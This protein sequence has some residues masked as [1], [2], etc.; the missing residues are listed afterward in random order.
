[1]TRDYR[2]VTPH[3]ELVVRRA[4][5]ED[6]AAL[7]AI[8]ESTM[9]WLETLGLDAGR[10][11]M[12]LSEAIVARIA[13]DEVYLALRDDVAVGAATLRWTPDALWS[14]LP[15]DAVYLYSLMVRRDF[16]GQQVGRYVLA[17]ATYLAAAR[18]RT[19]LRLD[20]DATNPALLAYY[21]R[22]GFTYRGEVSFLGREWARFE[23]TVLAE[24]IA[25]PYGE[26]V[27][28]RGSEED[29]AA[30]V[31]IEED[32]IGWVRTL[33]YKPG[34][35]PRPL[36]DIFAAAIARGQ[37]YLARREVEAAGKLAITDADDLWIDRPGDALYVHGLMVRRAHAGRD[38]GRALLR[39]AE[40]EAARR[41][42]SLLRLD[43]DALNPTLRAYYERA[44]FT[45]VDDVALPHWAAAR[46]EKSVARE[47]SS[48]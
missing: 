5:P 38:I 42:K 20:C 9:V 46:F 32:A 48:T 47:G 43:C 15:G 7:A 22:I 12:P 37:M 27:V 35:P 11:R 26:L 1:M 10:P 19:A 30:A 6:A 25:T 33:G 13:S 34:T 24:R 16:A 41:D 29:V 39:W 36:S 14:D 3:G 18:G 44:G 21:E 4:E 2:V 28:M 8:A 23:R 40:R 45:H 31:A 17:W